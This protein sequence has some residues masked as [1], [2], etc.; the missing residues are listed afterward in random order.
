[1]DSAVG[2]V[3]IYLF[4]P[5]KA[6][7]GVAWPGGRDVCGREQPGGRGARNACPALEGLGCTKTS[8]AF[9]PLGS[10]SLEAG[11]ELHG[12]GVGTGISPRQE[13]MDG[14]RCTGN[15]LRGA[16]FPLVGFGSSLL[17]I[18]CLS[19]STQPRLIQHTELLSVYL[20]SESRREGHAELSPP[21]IPHATLV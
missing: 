5:N 12:Q 14:Q 3:F 1:M 9:V 7:A 17:L 10:K 18:P 4:F 15:P 21:H 20:I 19:L 11:I 13:R 8:A 16:G 2:W 6:L